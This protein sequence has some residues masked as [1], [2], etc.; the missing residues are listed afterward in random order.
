M[1]LD[2]ASEHVGETVSDTFLDRE[3][4]DAEIVGTGNFAVHVRFAGSTEIV[5]MHP[6]HLTLKAA[7]GDD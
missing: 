3:P 4:R 2:E 5:T 7:A 6:R 1:T